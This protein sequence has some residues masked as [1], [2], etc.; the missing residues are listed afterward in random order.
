[1]NPLHASWYQLIYPS[2]IL[3]P[4][5][6]FNVALQTFGKHSA[7]PSDQ[8]AS[9]ASI[10]AEPAKDYSLKEGQTFSIKI[11]GREGRAR[12]TPSA[13]SHDAQGGSSGGFPMLAP[14]PSSRKR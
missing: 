2:L 4:R 3:I 1:M 13:T 14:P 10:P 9:N 12:P 5:F 6:D 7:N 11:P 8:S